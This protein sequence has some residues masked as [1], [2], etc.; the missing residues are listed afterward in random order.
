MATHY[1]ID[2]AL[3]NL[4]Y[5]TK[6]IR[7]KQ[8]LTADFIQHDKEL[9]YLQENVEDATAQKLIDKYSARFGEDFLDEDGELRTKQIRESPSQVFG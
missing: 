8:K 4:M 5:S 7:I 6:V 1:T 2:E 3:N 9:T